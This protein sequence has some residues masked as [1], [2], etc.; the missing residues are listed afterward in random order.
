MPPY[1]FLALQTVVAAVPA[2]S[3]C[4]RL[5][6][7]VVATADSFPD[8]A[9]NFARDVAGDCRDDFDALFRAGRAINHAATFRGSQQNFRLREGARRLLSRAVLLHPR[10]AVA[11][12]EYGTLLR[13]IGGV[14]VDA[15]RA[16]KKA[17]ELADQFP[18]STAPT[19]LAGLDLQRARFAQ[20][21]VDRARWLKNAGTIGV[22]TLECNAIGAFCTNYT[23][24][25][26]FNQSLKDASP[27]DPDLQTHREELLQYY[28]RVLHYDPNLVEAAERY[29]RELALGDEWERVLSA[30]RGFADRG[31]EPGFFGAVAALALDRMGRDA[32]ADSAFRAALPLLPDTLRRWFDRP[33]RG[34]DSIP[35]FWTRSRPLWVTPYNELLLGYRARVAYAL[36]VLRDREAEVLGPETPMG[37]ALLRYGWPTMIT[38]VDRNSGAVAAGISS[39]FSATMLENCTGNDCGAPSEAGDQGGGRWLFWTYAMN[40][41][42]MIFELTPGIKVARYMR[43]APAEQYASDLRAKDPL[44]FQSKIAPKQFRL[45][46]QVVR[47]RG[48]TADQTVA[49]IFGLVPAQQMSLPPQ[50]S[51]TTGLFCFRD[52]TGFPRM[53]EQR[54][55]FVP[56][57][58]LALNYRVP[59]P[60]GRYFYSLEALAPAFGGAATTRGALLA[61]R[62]NP[63]SLLLSDLLIAHALRERADGPSLTVQDLT[64]DASRTLTV[65]P[66]ATVW[67]VWEV[68]G[69]T[70]GA[71]GTARYD[72]TLTLED[73][74]SR[75]LGVRLLARLGL[76]S[77]AGTPA[78]SLSWSAERQES[79]DGRALEYVAVGLPEDAKGS[80][81]LVVT[82]RDP[83]TG[84]TASTARVI[85]VAGQ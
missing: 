27:I 62:W 40:R 21:W 13:K 22:S 74:A 73:T 10:D 39:A 68:Y 23:A 58:A 6:D 80:Y 5:A 82:V 29:A 56:G 25:A 18:D 64:L 57:Q 30:A 48:A 45:P 20:D 15:Q 76:A 66:G 79:P 33:P 69:I 44:V 14:Q 7:S 24:P 34:L 26:M 32:A 1:L 77:A 8:R 16:L 75:P 51:V 70:P 37:D 28:E 55:A 49:E 41:P 4:D 67:A 46:A 52:T 83:A 53:A 31:L 42:S 59:L 11:W 50:D 63:D 47:F 17:V 61:P 38:Q 65:L 36:L 54:G 72:V 60:E 43:D 81:R 19:L 71:R 12:L 85:E 3:K 9:V 2:P 84:R 35:D 78:V